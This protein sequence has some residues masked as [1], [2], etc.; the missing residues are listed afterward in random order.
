MAKVCDR[1]INLDTEEEINNFIEA[2]RKENIDEKLIKK[3]LL[4]NGKSIVFNMQT[5]LH[6]QTWSSVRKDDMF[7]HN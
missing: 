1:E 7:L 5:T 4:L 6:L 2:I 3:A